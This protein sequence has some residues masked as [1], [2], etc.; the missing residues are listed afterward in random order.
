MTI[1]E[2]KAEHSQILSSEIENYES[3]KDITTLVYL[4][5]AIAFIGFTPLI[6]LVINYFKKSDVK[7]SILESHFRWQI[8]T[9]WWG[10]LW[11]CI[12]AF[13]IF[14]IILIPVGWLISA[15]LFIWWVY[16][17]VKGWLRL[18]KGL[19]I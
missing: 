3:L 10:L 17:I 4:L 5:Q 7:G 1:D 15:G 9:F 13:C 16:R 8:R 6:A 12:A 2:N 11:F 18:N 19:T 14:T